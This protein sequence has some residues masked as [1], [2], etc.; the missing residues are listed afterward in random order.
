MYFCTGVRDSLCY[1]LVVIILHTEVGLYIMFSVQHNNN[2]ALS[3]INRNVFVMT[4]KYMNG[5]GR[6]RN[7]CIGS[8]FYSWNNNLKRE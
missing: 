1:Y 7:I 2:A 4:S 6:V 5:P 3:L 8:F